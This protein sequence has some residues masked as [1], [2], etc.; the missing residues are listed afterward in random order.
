MRR[1]AAVLLAAL[2]LDAAFGELP[3]RWHPVA[4][5]GQAA[6]WLER[7]MTDHGRRDTAA[8]GIGF[9]LVAAGAA[10]A[11]GA[12]L[13][14]QVRGGGLAG[15]AAEAFA[16]KQAL[17]LRALIEHADAVR[18]ALERS[19]LAGARE[20]AGR[21]VS[22]NTGELPATLVASAAIE[23]VAENLS[24]G[25]VAPAA[26]YLAGGL[27]GAYAYRAVNTLDAMVGYR[28]RGRFGM[29]P[30]RLD[31]ALN[32]APARLTAAV[33]LALR[34]AALRRAGEVARDARSTASPNAGW[35]MAAMACALG[36]RLEK[37]GHHV[38]NGAGREPGA[39]DIARA[40]G[41]AAAAAAVLAAGAAAALRGRR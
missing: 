30:A 40:A 38:L 11:A 32:L 22:R 37:R 13:Q 10:A 25:V 2:A 31:D 16:L 27:A 14:R 15:F 23:S 26:W 3:N 28:S 7:R 41:L 39:Q 1:R 34:P 29:V 6:N 4:R 20:A 18:R 36:T 5:F 9:T 21:M 35:P 33:L 8:A 19:D 12:G 24:D 17:A